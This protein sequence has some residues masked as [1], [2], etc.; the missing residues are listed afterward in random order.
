MGHLAVA[1]AVPFEHV[2]TAKDS[3]ET[4][5]AKY[6]PQ[7][8][9]FFHKRVGC[10]DDAE[11]LAQEVFFRLIRRHD[12]QNIKVIRSYLF[13]VARNVLI[14]SVRRNRARCSNMHEDLSDL[15]PDPASPMCDQII[16]A[17]EQS[18]HMKRGFLQLPSRTR[19]IFVLRRLAGMQHK[20]IAS[21]LGVSISTVE[22][23]LKQANKHL[24]NCINEAT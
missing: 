17:K 12:I 9:S 10:R 4:I 5:I 22:K 20:E 19:S 1:R 18:A 11:D 23:H 13:E 15:I 7:I 14:D 16:M 21:S 24:K 8:V 3:Y 2:D 6:R